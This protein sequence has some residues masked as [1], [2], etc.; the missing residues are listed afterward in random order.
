MR[1]QAG[2]SVA[3]KA[4]KIKHKEVRPQTDQRKK[5]VEKEALA[6]CEE[7]YLHLIEQWISAVQERSVDLLREVLADVEKVVGEFSAT[8]TFGYGIAVLMK[9]TKSVLHDANAEAEIKIFTA[10]R[11]KVKDSYNT[12]NAL[13]PKDYKPKLKYPDIAE[14]ANKPF[15]TKGT[16]AV[17]DLQESQDSRPN[18]TDIK[19]I[20]FHKKEATA[21]PSS[22]MS[23]P[24]SA[25]AAAA[26][27]SHASRQEMGHP[28][29]K[30]SADGPARA[31]APVAKMKTFSLINM[32]RTKQDP[33]AVTSAAAVTTT[34]ASHNS[35][36][37]SSAAMNSAEHKNALALVAAAWWK[38][39]PLEA[40]KEDPRALALEFL[41]QAGDHFAVG[42]V[43]RHALARSLE[44]AIYEW[45]QNKNNDDNRIPWTK[46]YW[47][48]VYALTAAI[49]GKEAPG[50]LMKMIAQGHFST[51]HK[52]V[53]LSDD[54]LNMSFEGRPLDMM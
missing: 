5:K 39:S 2:E 3:R 20:K 11:K 40:P 16:H 49:C 23:D 24:Q 15:A 53:A 8:F 47:D 32:F 1:G 10:F 42:T 12:R 34:S 51:P 7:N 17:K 44:A 9:E 31:G 38:K 37:K 52:V 36:N 41:T 35:N 54:Q 22:K 6:L 18:I 33:T 48:K 50:S 21:D 14:M 13:V 4:Q 19:I 30:P 43:D 28:Q 25:V 26:A 27:T 45:S 46:V 29:K